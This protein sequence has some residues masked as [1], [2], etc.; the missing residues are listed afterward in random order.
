MANNASLTLFRNSIDARYKLFFITVL[1]NFYKYYV[2][3][4]YSFALTTPPTLSK[5][6]YCH[7]ARI[8]VCRDMSH[9][10]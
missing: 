6:S 5:E 10:A 2:T 8:L 7:R 3:E 1:H 4:K 9:Q